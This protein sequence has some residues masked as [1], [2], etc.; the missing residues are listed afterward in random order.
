[1]DISFTPSFVRML[2]SLPDALVE[3]ALQ[4]IE[5]FR[6]ARNHRALKVRKLGGRLTGRFAFSVNYR[7]R[8]VFAYRRTNPKEALLLAV[9]DHDVYDR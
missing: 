9:G 3:E 2:K 5:P 8:V 6:D 1:M 7:T 4:K